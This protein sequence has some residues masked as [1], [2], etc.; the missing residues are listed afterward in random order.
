MN[1]SSALQQL[2]LSDKERSYLALV[3]CKAIAGYRPERGKQ[4]EYMEGPNQL[5]YAISKCCPY[6]NIISQSGYIWKG[7]LPFLGSEV[8]NSLRIEADNARS[9]AVHATKHYM[10][11]GSKFAKSLFQSQHLSMF[12]KEY[13]PTADDF[14]PS[15]TFYHWY[16]SSKDRVEPHIDIPEFGLSI[17]LLL[18]HTRPENAPH[19]SAFFVFP[20]GKGATEVSLEEGEAL[21]LFSGS[22]VHARS[23]PGEGENVTTV[24]WGFQPKPA[25]N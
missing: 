20:P 13:V 2:Q 25:Q 16:E 1:W 10:V 17:L 15:S 21:C 8:I 23:S 14:I 5:S 18:R 7:N 22:V 12:I 24:S 9:R 4:G 11:E 19:K 6:G 3:L